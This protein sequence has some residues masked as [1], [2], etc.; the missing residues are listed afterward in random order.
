MKF[1]IGSIVKSKNNDGLIVLA[2]K[3]LALTLN[4]LKGLKGKVLIKGIDEI[5]KAKIH[6]PA[7]SDYVIGKIKSY[8][9]GYCIL[10]D[11][12]KFQAVFEEDLTQ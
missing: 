8:E 9:G 6:A 5:A 2:T 4:N 1:S 12:F 11:D 10:D 3:N 7:G